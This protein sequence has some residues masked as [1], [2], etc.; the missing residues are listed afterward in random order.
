[1]INIVVAE[2]RYRLQFARVCSDK[3]SPW[4]EE[5]WKCRKSIGLEFGTCSRRPSSIIDSPDA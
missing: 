1:M 5:G 3:S 4:L 2:L